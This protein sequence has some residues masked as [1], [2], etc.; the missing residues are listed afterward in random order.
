MKPD[1]PQTFADFSFSPEV[2][3]AIVELGYETPTQIQL[4]SIP[5]LM[6]GSTDFLGLAS[7]G[8]G[9][10]AAFA[11]PLLENMPVGAKTVHGLIL[12]PTRELAKQVTEQI[13]LLGKYKKIK[14]VDIYG[15]SSF[16]DQVYAIEHGASIVVGTPGRIIDHLERK[17]LNLNDV[18]TVI[19]DEADEMISMGFREEIEKI[20]STVK[21]EVKHQTW[22]FSATMSPDVRKIADKFLHNPVQVQINKNTGVSTTITQL[23]YQV[24][25]NEKPQVVERLIDSIADFYGLIFC[26][27][28]VQV[29]QLTETL[30]DHGYPA[31]CLHGDMDQNAR[32]RNMLAFKAKRVTVMVCTDVA[33]RGID[34]KDLTHVIN[35]SLPRELDLYVH[36]IGRTARGGKT[37][38]ALNLVSP[39]HMGLIPRIERV[40]KTTMTRAQVPD[41]G[42][43]M[44][45]KVTKYLT[46]FNNP[47][48]KKFLVGLIQ[49]LLP[50]TGWKEALE[51][52]T[53]EEIVARFLVRALQ[54]G[55]AGPVSRPTEDKPFEKR[56]Y[57]RG[58]D[59]GAPR[60]G[61]R[62]GDRGGF[63]GPNR[64]APRA[65]FSRPSE[66]DRG[67]PREFSKPAGERG[68]FRGPG[69]DRGAPRGDRGGNFKGPRGSF[70]SRPARPDF[71]K[72]AGAR[73]FR[74]DDRR[75]PKFAGKSSA[76]KN[77][78]DV[79]PKK[80]EFVPEYG[81][82]N[83]ETNKRERPRKK[84][85]NASTKK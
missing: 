75:G 81:A 49:N 25:E 1:A 14:V 66:G 16:R 42:S 79:S 55:S 73:A 64:S 30:R 56:S 83:P 32:E 38:V 26:Q 24:R 12:C 36:R 72:P 82:R 18:K 53:K 33:S 52:M 28:K 9:K 60:G 5:V 43:V 21:Q 15:G 69:A 29:I 70:E 23:F 3:K 85:D 63:R 71:A 48:E 46:D 84:K 19:L 41:E 10:T 40:T 13:R 22:L 78:V 77:Y 47:G 11:L 7:T 50:D 44:K 4:D 62:G 27:T 58:P 37:G 80:R 2:A 54:T 67:A 20:L 45:L 17:T 35:Y 31:D 74:P 6:K 61:D 59:R 68:N 65:D 51:S 8:T 34:V 57:G 39:M 76:T